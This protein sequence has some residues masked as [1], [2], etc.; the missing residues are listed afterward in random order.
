MLI[1]V[2]RPKLPEVEAVAPYLERMHKTRT[3]SNF[4]PLN[5]ELEARMAAHFKVSADCVVTCSSATTGL[6]GA[7]FLSPEA[8]YVLPSF[9]FAATPLAVVAARKNLEFRDVREEDWRVDLSSA[10][11][12]VGVIDVMPF[13]ALVETGGRARFRSV[14]FDAAASI[15]SIPRS[16]LELEKGWSAVFSLHATKVL[17]IGEGGVAVFGSPKTAH[18]FRKWTNFG[19]GESRTSSFWGTNGKLSEIAAAYGLAALDGWKGEVQEW[20]ESNRRGARILSDLGLAGR[21][22]AQVGI[23]P[24][25]ITQ[26][27]T[28]QAA[29]EITS[30][31]KNKKI[32]TKRWWPAGCHTMPAFKFAPIKTLAITDLLSQTVVGVPMY[33]GL[34]NSEAERIREAIS[35]ACS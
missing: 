6:T 21:P 2:A 1:P 16:G 29:S 12:R 8:E 34:T 22:N 23:S 14:I 26:F 17:G 13:G 24:Y 31:L 9:T 15:G 3:F 20:E 27:A 19:F 28:A 30:A 18:D 7:A 5:A 4:G 35:S 33:R 32:E 25:Q 10:D 11:S